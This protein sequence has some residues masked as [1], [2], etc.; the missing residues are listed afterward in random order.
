MKNEAITVSEFNSLINQT[1]SFA[2]P[3]VVVEG[4]VSSYK[5]NQGKW[6]FFDLKDDNNVVSCFI[7]IFQLNT[8]VEDGMLVRVKALPQLTKWGKFSLTVRKV[9][10]AGEGSVKRA[11]EILKKK[12]EQEGL[13][14]PSRKRTLPEIPQKVLLITSKQAAAFN[15]FVTV[16][17]DR[18][19][20]IEIDH[21]QVQVQGEAAHKQ[22]V[23]AIEYGNTKKDLYQVLVLIRGG[24]SFEDLQ[25]FSNEEVVRAVY[26][27]AIPTIVG[28]G[29]E[30]DV[31]LSELVA[32]VRAATPTDAARRLVPESTEL[33]SRI[34]GFMQSLHSSIQGRITADTAIV[35]R[36]N[37]SFEIKLSS[38]RH[39]LAEIISKSAWN[40]NNIIDQQSSRLM[41]YKKLLASL[42]PSA[43]L[44]RGY[45]I[46]RV[47]GTVLKNANSIKGSERIV[48][49]L[50][51]G[52][53]NL[54]ADKYGK[55]LE[56]RGQTEIEF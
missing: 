51:Q 25:V 29:H 34:D 10:L 45:S 20:G 35:S 12:L 9:E 24:G 16:I 49:Q 40:M 48:L 28:I 13:F 36:F 8:E 27:S 22:I 52:S 33:V 53:L 50:H 2:Y 43:I 18:F 7:P 5:I 6:V 4:E 26:A 56:K 3:E 14:D 54:V 38:M 21:Y 44:A 31:S 39:Q 30:D 55:E 41:S 37:H 32:D 15:D 19:R 47:D 17:N 46:A 42:D 1:L 23:D 11:F